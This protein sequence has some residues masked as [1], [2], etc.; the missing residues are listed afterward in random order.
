MQT[1]LTL[2]L[3]ERLIE[4][5]KSWA[6]SRGVSLSEAVSEFFSQLPDE[7]AEAPQLSPWLL[8]LR[9]LAETSTGPGPDDEKLPERYIDYLESK[10]E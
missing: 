1:K 7:R 9:A 5:A 6:R 2:R 8:G 4:R 10:Y 3:D